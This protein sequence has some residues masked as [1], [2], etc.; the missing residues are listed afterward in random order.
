MRNKPNK[1][2]DITFQEKACYILKNITIKKS[3]LIT[4]RHFGNT[5]IQTGNREKQLACLCAKVVQGVAAPGQEI[6]PHVTLVKPQ[7][8]IFTLF[9]PFKQA[10][11]NVVISEF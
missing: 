2:K 3:V 7:H 8:V 4:K 10:R 1:S 11:Y 9:L 5:I 6:V